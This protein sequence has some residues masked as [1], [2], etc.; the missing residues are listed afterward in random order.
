MDVKNLLIVGYGNQGKAWAYNLRDSGWNISIG[1][2]AESKSAQLA[3]LQNLATI[4][5]DE[6]SLEKHK[7]IALLTP[8]GT[9]GEI[10]ENLSAK[11]TPG[12]TII[13]AHGYSFMTNKLNEKY[14]NLNHALLAP[15]S[16]ASELR[17]QYEAKGKLAGF[18]SLESVRPV[19]LVPTEKFILKLA[20]ELGL[21][22]GPFKT[23]F[24]EETEADLFSEQSL[25]CSV[26]PYVA[27]FC[28][29]NLRK[30]GVSKELSYFESW[31]EMKLIVDTLVKAGPVKF[32]QLI[33]PNALVGGEKG[34]GALLDGEFLSKFDGLLDDINAGRFYKEAQ[35]A[36][37]DAVRERVVQS[38]QNEE[39]SEV[40][41]QM[42]EHFKA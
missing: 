26:L 6:A 7:Y 12:T 28:Y 4:D 29:Q 34:K 41:E 14:P 30:H 31:Y 8:D 3:N 17:F 24:K 22:V 20:K 36:D 32:F 13:Y 42:K 25:L 37:F 33:S 11:L 18:Y 19:D 9:H 16:I 39:L 5:I 27:L 35:E 10:L 21:N 2:R 15:K 38:W 1:L 40:H 23:T